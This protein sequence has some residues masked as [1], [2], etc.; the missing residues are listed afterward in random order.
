METVKEWE[1]RTGKE[2]P[3]W[4]AVWHYDAYSE[5]WITQLWFQVKEF[6]E[7]ERE[8]GDYKKEMWEV[9]FEPMVCLPTDEEPKAV[10]LL[11]YQKAVNK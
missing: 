5:D 11:K 2:Y 6:Y 7:T 10:M 4:A 8:K 3:E 1:K 9:Y